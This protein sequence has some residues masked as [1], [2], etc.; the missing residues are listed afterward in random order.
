MPSGKFHD[1]PFD[2][3]TLA[4]LNLFELY[5]REW[6]PVF[7]ARP[8]PLRSAVHLF[9]FFAGPG[10]DS[11]GIPG[12]PIRLL[13]QLEAYRGKPGWDK[14]QICVHLFDA[15]S[16]KISHLKQNIGR[17]TPQLTGITLQCEPWNFDRAFAA[18]E[19]LLLDENAA[20]L[21]FIDQFGVDKVTD[22]VFCKLVAAPACDF[23]FFLT[24]STLYRFR[25]HPAIR[26]KISRPDDYYHVH[27]KVLEYYHELLPDPAGYYLAP[28]S[29][30]KGSNIYGVIFGSR[31]PLG[32]DKFLQVA[33]QQ[34]EV[35]GEAN[36]DIGGENM[37][38]GSPM[39]PFPDLKP[40]K[41]ANFERDLEERLR[42]GQLRHEIDV[43]KVCFEHGVMRRH[44]AP[45][46][47]KLKQEKV[48]EIGFRVP[49]LERLREPRPIRMVR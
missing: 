2:E 42:A 16:L 14:V 23:L 45:I 21:V 27:R 9:D 26:Q 33:W 19:P 5:T 4:K 17:L 35:N 24:S 46:L 6:L 28:F 10:T 44:A 3:G 18:S 20:K 41:V 29:I 40:L 37:L 22:D 36:F 11:K 7:L 43:M 15:S 39:L 32:M 1:K 34:D 8:T 13:K 49:D 38:P 47:A 30:K 31:H 12:S 48:I 25:D